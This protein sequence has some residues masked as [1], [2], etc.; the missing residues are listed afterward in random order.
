[1]AIEP[2][3]SICCSKISDRSTQVCSTDSA[4]SR[5]SSDHDC[6]ACVDIPMS[7]GFAAVAKDS[8]RGNPALQA[9]GIVA[10]AVVDGPDSSEYQL[11]SEFSVPPPYFTPLRSIV[12]L[13]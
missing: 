13:I 1:M 5:H 9:S 2:A 12:L 8:I 4:E 10:F 3:D 11:F 6:G 7:I